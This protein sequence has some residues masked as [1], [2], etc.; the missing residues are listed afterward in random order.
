M[1]VLWGKIEQGMANL[2]VSWDLRYVNRF[3]GLNTFSAV[4]IIATKKKIIKSKTTLYD[5]F[6]MLTIHVVPF[7]ILCS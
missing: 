5:F 6:K 2:W 7:W 1:T 4:Q 3:S